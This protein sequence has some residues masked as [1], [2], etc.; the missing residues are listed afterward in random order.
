MNKLIEN[1]ISMYFKVKEFFA[2][3]L[4]TLVTTATGLTPIVNIFNSKLTELQNLVTIADQ[5]NSGYAI[6]KQNN[7]ERLRDISLAV[8]GP[9]WAFAKMN[10]NEILASKVLATKSDLDAKRDTDIL[11]WCNR[12]KNF[13]IIPA[14]AAG[15]LPLGATAAMLTSLTTAVTSFEDL[16]QEPA[17]KRSEGVAAG[18]EAE[19]KIKEIDNQLKIIDGVMGAFR[20]SN[21]LLFNQYNADRLIDDNAAGI[22]TPDVIETIEAG[23]VESI[24]NIPFVAER[25]FKLN[26][27]SSESIEW[28]LS[29]DATNPTNSLRTLEPNSVSELRSGSLAS[30]GDFLIIR[31]PSA[32]DIIVEMTI[33]E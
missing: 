26:N 19:T 20:T 21:S 16:L 31:N 3:N 10:A 2:N 29:E 18:K 17:D 22:G 25:K 8:A 9:L 33:V 6:Q 4:A 11:F 15:I 24:F 27:T 13:A 30:S 32:V 12:L 5:N 7:R 1:R 23:T 28:G 14:N